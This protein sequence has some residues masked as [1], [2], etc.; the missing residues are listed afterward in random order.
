MCWLY[1]ANARQLVTAFQDPRAGGVLR[2]LPLPKCVAAWGLS[3]PELAVAATTAGDAVVAVGGDS[4]ALSSQPGVWKQVRLPSGKTVALP[5]V[6]P[7]YI[8]WLRVRAGRGSAPI[9]PWL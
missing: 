3:P 8:K 5:R 9:A 7:K 2:E 1:D 6:P 4:H